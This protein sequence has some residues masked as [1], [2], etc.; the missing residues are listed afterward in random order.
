MDPTAPAAPGRF[1][2]RALLLACLA[3]WPTMGG[4]AASAQE[5][6][7]AVIAPREPYVE[8]ARTL[9]RWIAAE[10]EAKGLPAASIALVDDQQV[11]WARGFGY[12]DPR[13]RVPAD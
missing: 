1:P 13:G 5:R 3:A 12:S 2:S 11:V 10:V 7:E 6:A 4:R 8:A 9:E